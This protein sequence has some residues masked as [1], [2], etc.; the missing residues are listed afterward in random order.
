MKNQISK[1][2]SKAEASQEPEETRQNFH[3]S[4]EELKILQDILQEAE[5][6]EV[7]DHEESK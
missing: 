7:I 2:Q 1:T 6:V 3:P 4:Q 5:P